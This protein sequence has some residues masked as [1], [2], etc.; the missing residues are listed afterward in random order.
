MLYT[1]VR[2]KVERSQ[3]NFLK[4]YNWN[5]EFFKKIRVTVATFTTPVTKTPNTFFLFPTHTA[6]HIK[7]ILTKIEKTFNETFEG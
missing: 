5:F 1:P 3:I 7:R 4:V 2:P 6:E